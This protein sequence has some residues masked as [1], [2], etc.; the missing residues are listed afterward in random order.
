MT[1]VFD[2]FKTPLGDMT[3]VFSDDALC[4]LDF[5]DGAERIDTLLRQRF[6]DYEKIHAP[7]PHGIR[8][9]VAAYF[10]GERQA[11]E[12]QKL[13]TKGTAFQQSVW[14]A[15]QKIPYGKTL[16]YSELAEAVG[17]PN[18][19]RAVGNANGRNPIAIIIPCHRVIAING[20]LAGY[21]GG[22][23]RKQKLLQLEGAQ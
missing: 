17:R 1:L 18:A 19:V 14:R 10:K 20:A 21:A 6:P 13:D 7:N 8:N 22:I 2:S 15:L 23:T 5:S 11:F 4:L 16:S 3:A 9:K 12:G